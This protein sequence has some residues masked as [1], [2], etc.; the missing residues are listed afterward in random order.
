[1]TLT[2]GLA[3]DDVGVIGVADLTDGGAAG[4]EDA[5]HLG[6]RHT[7]DS[8]LALLTHQLAGVTGGTGDSS[9]L[10]RLELDGV[11]ERTDGDVGE[12]QSVARLD[13]GVRTGHDGLTDLEALG[14]QD[15]ALLTVSV[16]QQSDASGTVRIVLDRGNLGGHAV[17]V[18]L[19]VDHAVTTLH[20]AAWWRV[21]MRPLLLRPA[22]LGR[23]SRRDFSGLVQVISEK[24]EIV[25]QRLPAEVGL[26]CFT[27]ITIPFNRNPLAIA[28]R[29]SR[30]CLGCDDTGRIHGSGRVHFIRPKP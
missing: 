26:R 28:D 16:V 5:A 1:M 23:G 11:D 22:F 17:L 12:G 18:A 13:V 2:A 6:G 27:A 14:G 8:V 9:A 24:S 25:C 4:N 10:A 15:V 3:D 20:A 19:E 7:D 29:D 30:F 21:V